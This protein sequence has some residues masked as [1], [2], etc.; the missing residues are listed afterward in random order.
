MPEKVPPLIQIICPES[1]QSESFKRDSDDLK[2][3]PELANTMKLKSH[4]PMSGAGSP[5]LSGT[6][7]FLQN[8]AARK[9]STESPT[10]ESV[11]AF[12]SPRAAAE[13]LKEAGSPNFEITLNNFKHSELQQQ[14]PHN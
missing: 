9:F 1:Q 13:K 12:M 10:S 6:P 8:Q 5:I 3:A 4:F 7:T 14:S 2:L 11:S